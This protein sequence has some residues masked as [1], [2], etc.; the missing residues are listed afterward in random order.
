MLTDDV[1]FANR[2]NR[3][4]GLN[5]LRR[6]QNL[7][8]SFRRAAGRILFHF[9]MRFDNLSAEVR[10]KEFGSLAR[11]PKQRIHPNTEIR[12]ENDWDRSSSLFN[13]RALLLGMTRCSDDERFAVGERCPANFV[14]RVG[15]TEIDR[16]V[17]VF[18]RWL[19][20]IAQIALRG[21]LNFRIALCKIAN[22]LSHAPGR[23]D[24]QHAHGK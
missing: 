6:F 17:T 12:C 22:R 18:Y 14:D 24:E 3:Y 16:Y 11:Q 23:A 7:R 8:E 1:A 13:Y 19:D 15:V 2:F 4:F 20:R 9:M 21:D 5:L 10:T